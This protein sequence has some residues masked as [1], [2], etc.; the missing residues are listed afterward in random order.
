[1]GCGKIVIRAAL[2]KDSKT[3]QPKSINITTELTQNFQ[4]DYEIIPYSPDEA[5]NQ[6]NIA[7]FM[8]KYVFKPFEYLDNVIGVEIN[9]N[10]VFY[11]PVKLEEVS[12]L[13]ANLSELEK[14]LKNLENDL[15][16]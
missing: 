16:L 14:E 15:A 1:L 3:K 9:F 7:D 11:I 13:T 2:K 10:K 8:A 12:T 4:K 6:Q 5:T